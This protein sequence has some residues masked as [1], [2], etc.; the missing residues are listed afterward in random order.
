[1][2]K[3]IQTP[4]SSLCQWLSPNQIKQVFK[5]VLLIF[6]GFIVSTCGSS[7]EPLVLTEISIH[8]SNGNRLDVIGQQETVLSV[9]GTDQFG[10]PFEINSEVQW[11]V[12]NDNVSLDQN[13]KV[14]AQ[15]VGSS[16]ITAQVESM[17]QNFNLNVWDS[18]AP[19][20]EIYVSDVGVDRNGP[21]Y[22]L[23]YDETG[24]YS[25]I[26]INTGLSKPQDI[27]FLEDQGIVLVSNLSGNNINKYDIQTGNL[28]GAFATSLAGPTRIDIG[29]DNRLYVI[30][31]NGGQVKRYELDGTFVD[32]FTTTSI[33]QAIGMAWDSDGNLYVSSFNNGANGFV[34]KFDA[35]GN[36]L[37]QFINSD[38]S[39]PTDIWFDESGDLFVN[40]WAG[41]S[42]KKFSA[43]GTF[44][45]VFISNVSQPEG[46]AFLDDGS[47]LIGASGSS[48][49]AM[50][51]KSGGALSNLVNSGGGGLTT[52]NAVVTRKVNQ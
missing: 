11:S 32:N 30:L 22:I 50:Y 31:W 15:A 1:M 14:T 10:N 25:S 4:I 38:L 43:D 16:I 45:G 28:L 48:T 6:L 21:H 49:I 39:G 3:N 26:Y 37:G 23:K 8:S 9:S 20:T 35:S 36:D 7:E 46:V 18:S 17:Q 19:T 47:I 12:D 34:T 44:Q 33:N 29:P 5:F 51:S 41:N 27:V 52:P 24:Q 40:D 2:N 42:V 13:G